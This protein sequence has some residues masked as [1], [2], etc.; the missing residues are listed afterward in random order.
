MLGEIEGRRKRLF[1]YVSILDEE[2]L[3]EATLKK[4]EKLIKKI[5]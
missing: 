5:T 3:P 1:N 2:R 4:P